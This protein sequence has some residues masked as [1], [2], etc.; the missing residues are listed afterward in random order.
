[1]RN[2]VEALCWAVCLPSLTT[3]TLRTQVKNN[4]SWL[5]GGFSL[6]CWAI[7]IKL[8]ASHLGEKIWLLKR[9]GEWLRKDN[10][11]SNFTSQSFFWWGKNQSHFCRPKKKTDGKWR[12]SIDLVWNVKREFIWSAV[13]FFTGNTQQGKGSHK[14]V[15]SDHTGGRNCHPQGNG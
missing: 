12:E 4:L 1:M 15:S 6:K 10:L 14:C 8:F 2:R 11:K 13:D 9:E 3:S 5:P 7:S